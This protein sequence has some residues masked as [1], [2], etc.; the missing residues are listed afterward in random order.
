MAVLACVFLGPNRSVGDD[1]AIFTAQVPPNVMILLDNSGSMNEIM[2][3]PAIAQQADLVPGPIGGCTQA[4][5]LLTQAGN[6]VNA[7]AGLTP[8]C[9]I[10]G[11]EPPNS[12]G[13]ASPSPCFNPGGGY[14]GIW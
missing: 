14:P 6:Y 7:A 2:W 4:T 10:F 11:I 1:T 12:C 8:N 3:H 5:C 9:P 13:A